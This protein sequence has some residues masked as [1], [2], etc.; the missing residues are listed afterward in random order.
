M[1][2]AAWSS[3]AGW[4]A[5]V[6]L[7]LEAVPEPQQPPGPCCLEAHPEPVSLL[8]LERGIPQCVRGAARNGHFCA[9][10]QEPGAATAWVPRKLLPPPAE[11]KDT[12]HATEAEPGGGWCALR[13][14][15]AGSG[16]GGLK[17]PAA[18]GSA[19]QLCALLSEARG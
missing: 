11:L 14:G 17:V 7:A 16:K 19:G 1:A 3:Q 18:P 9:V 5:H 13:V 8:R 15:C 4:R 10:V 2:P 6:E 12:D